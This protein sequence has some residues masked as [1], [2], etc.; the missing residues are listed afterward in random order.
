MTVKAM[1]ESSAPLM[2]LNNLEVIRFGYC[3]RIVFTHYNH[4]AN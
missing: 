3:K 4:I 1:C 2:T